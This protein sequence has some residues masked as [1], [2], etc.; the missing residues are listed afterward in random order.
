VDHYST[1]S[2]TDTVKLGNARDRSS[3]HIAPSVRT[4]LV[5]KCWQDV[6]RFWAYLRRE[7]RIRKAAVQLTKFDDRL[8][9]DMGIDRCRIERAVRY[10]RDYYDGPKG[11]GAISCSC[12][13]L[14]AAATPLVRT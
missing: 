9:Q 8:L 6:R 11:K 2:I 14:Q 4:N 1:R 3:R 7:R 13:S 5:K 10:G 12:V